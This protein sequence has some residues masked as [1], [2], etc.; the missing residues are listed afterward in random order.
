[1]HSLRPAIRCGAALGAVVAL[2][3]ACAVGPNFT[4]PSP[5]DTGGY[6]NEPR[7]PVAADGGARQP[8]PGAV[9]AADWWR[10]FNSPQ[11]DDAV[12]KAIA[13]NPTL[14]AA[15]ASLRQAQ[16]SLRAGR[17]VFFPQVGALLD[18]SRQRSAPVEQGLATRGGVFNVVSLSGTV[19]YAL[20]VF[21]GERRKV[22]SLG[23]QADFQRNA[24]LAAYLAL[25][26]NVVNT[27][28]ARSAYAAQIR[29]TE[30]LIDLEAQQLRL[31]AVQ[32]G[33]GTAAYSGMLEIRGLIASNRALLAPLR[34]RAD[35]A[36]D[37]LALLEG[38]A[39]SQAA[40]P[41][42]EFAD[43]AAPGDPPVSLPSDLVRQR[44]DILEAEAMMHV[45]SANIGVATAAMFPSISLS[46]T[47]G[48]AAG[49]FSGLSA[50]SGRFWSIGPSVTVPLFQGGAL[51]YGRKAAIDAFQE[52]Q[53]AYRQT[54][55]AA[56]AQVADSL[57]ALDHDAEALQAQADARRAADE[58]LSLVN[59]NYRAGL[60]A[61][62][63]VLAADVQAHMATIAWLS[64]AAQ[65]E[66]DTVALYVALGGGWWNGPAGGGSG[67]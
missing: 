60:A 8:G 26:A 30:Q 53:A 29:V 32:V 20:D 56:F 34:Q 15:E 47:Y 41:E 7:S 10:M 21:G 27:G 31:A 6:L 22:E 45:A 19:G 58:A 9:L 61:Y 62:S 36:G 23:A 59:A 65:R 28:I 25:S 54:V 44:P 49:S 1:M 12:R 35:Q 2:L 38:V 43:L 66:Q 4:R 39:P 67:R 33:A 57:H 17:G 46:G 24:A 13:G 55:L 18:A 14:Q 42:I 51:W 52:S 50:A 16:D 64:A 48:A 5:P 40:L 63:D 11:L 37:L 3:G